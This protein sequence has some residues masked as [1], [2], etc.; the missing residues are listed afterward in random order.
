LTAYETGLSLSATYI[1]NI[2]NFY[3]GF[4]ANGP[5]TTSPLTVNMLPNFSGMPAL[6]AAYSAEA[7]VSSTN[8]LPDLTGNGRNATTTGV[9][10]GTASGNG[11]SGTVA[12]LNGTTTS[13]IDWPSGSVPSTFTICSL[14]RYTGGSSGRMFDGK[15]NNW[16]HSHW[17]GAA[18]V[19]HYDGWR[20]SGSTPSSVASVTN[21]VICTGTNWTGVNS[22][23][24]VVVNNLDVGTANGG[25]GNNTL[26][27]N[28][29]NNT[30]GSENSNFQFSQL[31]IWDSGLTSAQMHTVNN[32][33]QNYLN[34]GSSVSISSYTVSN[35]NISSN[36]YPNS[37][38]CIFRIKATTAT[39]PTA[40]MDNVFTLTNTGSVTCVADPLSVRPGYVFQF[41]GSNYL[42][43]AVNTPA[44]CTK[45]FWLYA[46]NFIYNNNC[47][48]STNYPIYFNGSSTYIIASPGSGC[49][50]PISQPAMWTFYAV[51]CN[52]TSVS[53]YMNGSPSPVITT[54]LT[55]RFS[56]DTTSIFF[57]AYCNSSSVIGNF[58][59][60]YLDDMRLYPGILTPA[61]INAIYQG[62]T[63]VMNNISS[64]AYQSSQ[65]VYGTY[66]MNANYT[67]PVMQLRLPSDSGGG[68]YRF[69]CGYLW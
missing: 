63:S 53:I 25:S 36:L 52:S 21:W 16:L 29:G 9:T 46:T 48:S 55:T 3:N 31:F 43:I 35:A 56:G 41:N 7:W 4:T 39:M 1:A 57:G 64:N 62:D 51:T 24:N 26:S 33:M 32:F 34:T 61:Q 23:Y 42:S 20:T 15:S 11:A 18:G 5:A 67:G 8:V 22:P 69:F 6:W 59:N 50:S 38:G 66:L 47:F 13:K 60:G 27:I 40:D 37:L 2:S 45:T 54:T 68:G 58:L 49:T 19:C 17:G 10:Y 44:I 12:Y 14:T 28:N 30:Q 65:G